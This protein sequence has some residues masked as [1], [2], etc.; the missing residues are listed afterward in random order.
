MTLL[1]LPKTKLLYISL[2]SSVCLSACILLEDET[3]DIEP[4][5]INSS[6]NNK[7]QTIHSDTV[8]GLQIRHFKCSEE[9]QLSMQNGKDLT[10]D[11]SIPDGDLARRVLFWKNVF[12]Y[13]S[14]T[15]YII[16]S[17]L[18]PEVV[19]EFGKPAIQLEQRSIN[20][21]LSKTR[22]TMKRRVSYYKRTLSKMQS[23]PQ[24]L[25]TQEE[26]RIALSMKHIKDDNKYKAASRT[27]G[28]QRGQKEFI[29][30]GYAESGRYLP[31]IKKIFS[32]EGIPE[33]L[34]YI[35]FVESS[36]NLKAYSKV[37]ASGVYQVMPATGREFIR[38]RGE[39]DERRDPIKS[40]IA[41]S[42]TK[43]MG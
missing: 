10:N 28:L 6:S 29:E 26:K 22:K 4:S 31:H 5:P 34:A 39:I 19:I 17:K 12:T 42:R 14:N 7:C 41:A 18:Y 11:F 13:W 20:K 35:A 38:I 8:N 1:S 15:E 9:A 2:L 21:E 37:G 27:L 33:E 40:A 25:F 36:F 32:Q 23:K 3:K 24:E 30:L 43:P 16:H